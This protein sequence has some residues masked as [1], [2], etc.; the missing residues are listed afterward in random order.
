MAAR[1]S[2]YSGVARFC[3]RLARA[4]EDGPALSRALLLEDEEPEVVAFCPQCAAR[5]FD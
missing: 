1:L 5:E 3:A 4:G 2:L